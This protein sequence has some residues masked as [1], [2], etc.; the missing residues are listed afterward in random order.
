MLRRWLTLEESDTSPYTFRL[1][2]VTERAAPDDD[3]KSFLGQEILTSYRNLDYLKSSYRNEPEEKLISY[4]KDYVLSSNS[5][6]IAKNVGQG[7]FGEILAGLIVSYFLGLAVPIRKLRW[8]FNNNRSTFCTD[9]IAH[10]TGKTVTDIYYYEIKSRLRVR[11]EKVGSNSNY[12]AVNAHNS[13]LKD[14]QTPTEGIADFLAR[15]YFEMCDFDESSKYQK[16]VKNP[17]QYNRNFELFF[18]IETRRFITD[19]LDELE[20]LPPT[21][22]PL[23]I[24]VVLINELR[25]LTLE[26]QQLAINTAINYVYDKS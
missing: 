10:N 1:I 11:K 2:N 13:L 18:V 16:I 19:I 14:E 6:Q 4:I 9:M 22:K 3:I 23:R 15:Y 17:Y 12:V 7:D 26:T 24:T 25:R 21:L 20:N 8:K 5:N